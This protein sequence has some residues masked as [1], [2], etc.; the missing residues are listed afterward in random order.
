MPILKPQ[1][2]HQLEKEIRYTWIGHS[3]AVI[4]VGQDNLLIDPVFSDRCF[5]SNY[6]GPKRYRKPACTVADLKKI[7]L[8]LVS[9][10]HYDHLDEVALS[11]L[12]KLYKPT[13]IAGLGSK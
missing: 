9:H 5:P 4:Q 2:N 13:F 8:V 7:D 1:L 11:E 6:V 12:H 3:T 10:D